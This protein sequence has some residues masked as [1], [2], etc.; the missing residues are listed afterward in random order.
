MW[1]QQTK[2]EKKITY[3][4]LNVCKIILFVW[5]VLFWN[6]FVLQFLSKKIYPF[7]FC[8]FESSSLEIVCF[9]AILIFVL[10]FRVSREK[11]YFVLFFFIW[12]KS[13][14]HISLSVLCWSLLFAVWC[15]MFVFVC[16][17]VCAK[18]IIVV[19]LFFV[20]FC[21][22]F[23]TAFFSVNI[24]SEHFQGYPRLRFVCLF[25]KFFPWKNNNNQIN[26]SVVFVKC[27]IQKGGNFLINFFP[28]KI[29]DN[30]FFT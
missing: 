22:C 10:F 30:F 18:S 1:K 17:F 26:S 7:P 15:L 4:I 20:L 24:S 21:F 29:S 5:L 12:K 16:L 11:S 28:W 8:K 2:P 19:Y 23:L 6:F 3:V 27:K 25:E 13:I 14:S 9:V